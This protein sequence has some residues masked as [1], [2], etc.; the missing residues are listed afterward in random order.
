MFVCDRSLSMKE[1]LYLI[2]GLA[3][4]F[5][6][7]VIGAGFFWVLYGGRTSSAFWSEFQKGMF[8]R[9]EVVGGLIIA[10]IVSVILEITGKINFL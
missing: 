3:V 7:Q 10:F 6:A 1:I 5:V 9:N 4:C 2:V 8:F